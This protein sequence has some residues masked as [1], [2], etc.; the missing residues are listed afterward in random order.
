MARH[1]LL[2]NMASRYE[3]VSGL[4][5]CNKNSLAHGQSGNLARKLMLALTL[6]S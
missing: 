3:W 4:I 2:L 6:P 5:F 1:G